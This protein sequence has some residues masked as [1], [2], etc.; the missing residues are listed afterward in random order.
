[1]KHVPQLCLTFNYFHI[2]RSNILLGRVVNEH[3]QN[4]IEEY[5]FFFFLMG[6]MSLDMKYE[7]KPHLK[8]IT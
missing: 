6:K 3:G 8:K 5:E 4:F 1:M 2:L 7:E